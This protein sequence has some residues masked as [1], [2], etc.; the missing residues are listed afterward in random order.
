MKSVLKAAAVFGVLGL[1]AGCSGETSVTNE[2][3]T[4]ETTE[5]LPAVNEGFLR[6]CL[7][8]KNQDGYAT[9]AESF[10]DDKK[11]QTV[12]SWTQGLPDAYK[13]E[14]EDFFAPY[15]EDWGRSVIIYMAIDGSPKESTEWVNLQIKCL[16]N[17]IEIEFPKDVY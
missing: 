2:T 10:Y 7:F 15:N 5:A 1:L 11:A 3:A 13:K 16:A 6:A 14:V 8:F 4:A 17:N 12:S 9:M